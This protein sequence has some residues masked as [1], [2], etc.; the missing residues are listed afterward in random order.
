M[1]GRLKGMRRFNASDC[2]LDADESVRRVRWPFHRGRL[3]LSELRLES[4][5]VRHVAGVC[6]GA[7][8]A[9]RE[10]QSRVLRVI[11]AVR[12]AALLVSCA[13]SPAR[14]G[15]RRLLSR[16]PAV[17]RD[18]MRNGVRAHGHPRRAP[19]DASVWKR[20]AQ[21]RTVHREI[22]A[23][24]RSAPADGRPPTAVRCRV[25]CNRRVRRDRTHRRRRSRAASDVPGREARRR[26]RADR[27]AAQVPL[28]RRGRVFAPP[29]PVSPERAR[30][31]GSAQ[32]IPP[33]PR[34][35]FCQRASAPL[36]ALARTAGS[37]RLRSEF[38]VQHF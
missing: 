16:C 24:R 15:T 12:T 28:E 30:R 8:P 14:V 25:R 27:S 37:S 26:H 21:R 11:G 19:R 36:L 20:G 10:L 17:S 32:R 33:R 18:W 7:R 4:G 3:A 9:Q 13:Q 35:V 2:I 31:Q 1:C 5:S 6:A 38:R 23:A 22:E 34:N 29:A